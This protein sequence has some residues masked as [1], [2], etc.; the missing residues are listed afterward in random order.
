MEVLIAVT[1]STI[2]AG[3]I[4]SIMV[5]SAGVFYKQSSRVE[6]GVGVN[7]VMSDI[8]ENL[9]QSKAV[10][11]NYPEIPPF[12]YTTDVNNL[13]L[14][15]PTLDSSGDLVPDTYDYVVYFIDQGNLRVKS[16][17]NIQSQ[18]NSRNQVLAKNVQS[19]HFQYFNASNQET[20]PANAIRV[21]ISLSLS[22]KNGLSVEKNVATSEAYLRND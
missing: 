1:V 2:V 8:K 9:K 5:N 13:I 12:Q 19:I 17:P 15:I 4:L 21:R 14:K 16:F 18:V 20:A 10:G 3:L 22:Q 6:Q 11:L 7:E